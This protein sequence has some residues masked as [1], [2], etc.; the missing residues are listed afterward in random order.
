MEDFLTARR[1]IGSTR[2][3]EAEPQGAPP[4]LK[5]GLPAIS[6]EVHAACATK[7]EGPGPR[8]ETVMADGQI[9]RIHIHCT[10]GEE[11]IVHCQYPARA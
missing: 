10:C 4:R 11:I 5:P 8:I 1:R 3:G 7:G 2:H 6:A 9:R